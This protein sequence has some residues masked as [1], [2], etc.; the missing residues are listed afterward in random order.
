LEKSD[1]HSKNIATEIVPASEFYK[2]EEYHQQYY[3]K[4]KKENKRSC[5]TDSCKL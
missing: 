4:I 5:G 1:Q 3:E 2:A